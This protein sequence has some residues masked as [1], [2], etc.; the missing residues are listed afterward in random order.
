[1]TSPAV[2][3]QDLTVSFRLADGA[4]YAAVERASVSGADGEFVSIVGPTGCGKTTLLNVAAGLFSPSSGSVSILGAPLT[5]LNRSAGYLFQSDALFPW[6]TALEN[7]AIGV[8]TA[9]MPRQEARERAQAW[10]TRVGLAGFG[11]AI[12]TCSLAAIASASGWRR[13]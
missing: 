10:L 1:M 6:K 5:G 2:A 13:S 9:G 4:A 3:F 11:D 12:R 8:E 7:V